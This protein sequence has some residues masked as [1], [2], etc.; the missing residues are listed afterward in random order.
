MISVEEAWAF[1]AQTEALSGHETVP[2]CDAAGRVLSSDVAAQR[3]QPPVHVSAMDG[4]AL[5][6]Q[7]VSQ[8]QTQFDIIGEVPA[9]NRFDG[10]LAEGQTVRIFTGAAV[11]DGADHIV[12]QE[13]VTRDGTQMR[14]TAPQD[15]PAHIRR[16]GQDFAGGDILLSA[17]RVLTAAD[18]ALAA[19]GNHADLCVT[20]RP[21]IAF[22]ASGDELKPAGQALGEVDIP[23]SLGAALAA[24]VSQWGGV[25][26]GH[27]LTPDDPAQFAAAVQA[28]P[29]ADIYVPIGGASVGA[30]DF[31]KQV[32]AD[33]GYQMVFSKIA[34][35][36]GKP[37][38]FATTAS[39]SA[40]SVALGLPGNP[41]SAMVTAHLFLR[42]LIAHLA[43]RSAALPWAHGRLTAA[44]SANGGR[45]NFLRGEFSIDDTGQVQLCASAKQD[46]ALTSVFSAANC[47]IR[48]PIEDAAR[49]PGDVVAFLPL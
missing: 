41:A 33:L 26:V 28:L 2:L 19:N 39:S 22:I 7:D 18:L 47:L 20:P 17:G 3:T 38:W 29:Q 23:D 43:G 8:G 46:S 11:P 27:A 13:D 40:S 9:G 37:C 10:S 44:L 30:Y 15:K 32:F 35:K 49:Q 14:L 4:Y 25:P 21:R 31:A 48:R 42:P 24:L 34:V 16:A 6:F 5:R 1:L 45:E 36:P 12:I